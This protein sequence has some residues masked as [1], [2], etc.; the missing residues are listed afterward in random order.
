M[1]TR[2]VWGVGIWV[3]TVVLRTL[4]SW[5]VALLPSFGGVPAAPRTDAGRDLGFTMF[6]VTPPILPDLFIIVGTIATL[7]AVSKRDRTGVPYGNRMTNHLLF[8]G[9]VIWVF[10]SQLSFLTQTASPSA[11]C[12]IAVRPLNYEQSLFAHTNSLRLSFHAAYLTMIVLGWQMYH[13]S[14]NSDFSK[15]LLMA[16]WIVALISIISSRIDFTADV[17]RGSLFSFVVFYFYRYMWPEKVNPVGM[18]VGADVL[19]TGEREIVGVPS[20]TRVSRRRSA[21]RSSLTAT[22]TATTTTP[23]PV[24]PAA[25]QTSPPPPTPATDLQAEIARQRSNYLAL[26]RHALTNTIY[27]DEPLVVFDC[28]DRTNFVSVG[29][30]NIRVRESGLDLPS[31]AHCR[32]GGMRLQAL[33]QCVEKVLGGNVPGDLIDVGVWRGGEAIYLRGVLNAYNC[34]DRTV[35]AV[36][37]FRG[38]ISIPTMLKRTLQFFCSIVPM[39]WVVNVLSVLTRLI[40]KAAPFPTVAE[41]GRNGR[42][43]QAWLQF[44]L[45]NPDVLERSTVG[46][47]IVSVK[48]AFKRYDLLDPLVECIQ[49]DLKVTLS[50]LHGR[51]LSLIRLGSGI[52][53]ADST[54]ALSH[55]YPRLSSGGFVIVDDY[56]GAMASID[57]FRDERQVRDPIVWIDHQCAIWRKQAA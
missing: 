45:A 19:S 8:C 25:T 42:Q 20:S 27:E 31:L 51:N 55:L 22:P 30:Y 57:R 24:A 37:T 13:P 41:P 23:P 15:R 40:P 38:P 14:V 9:G 34:H 47:D 16:A 26:L 11:E 46:T 2:V 54:Q 28:T 3:A 53:D 5:L 29:K 7:M 49:G 33:H 21:R 18:T 48:N 56:A 44:R 4:A 1:L 36:G 12:M 6:A 32:S 35:F 39:I 17:V 52:S 43:H 10:S 50:H